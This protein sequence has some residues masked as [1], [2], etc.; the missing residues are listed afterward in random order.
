MKRWWKW[1]VAVLI[2]LVIAAVAGRALSTRKAQ[3]QALAAAGAAKSVAVVELATSDVTRAQTREIAQGLPVTGALKAVNSAF[4]KARVAGELQGLSVREGD[5]VKAGQVIARIESTEFQSRLRQAQ[6]Q[7]DAARSQVDI[8]Q[9]QFDNNKALVDQG[10]IS[11]TALDTSAASLN[12]ARSTHQAALAAAD[13]ARKT[14]TDTVLVAPISGI[15][16]QRL[17]Q[18]GE[19]VP[20]D[21]RIVEIVD[22]SR[23]ELEAA[24]SAGDATQVRVGQSAVLR[25]EGS[26][27]PVKARV[28][29]IN[30]ST[31]AGSRSVMVYL[32]VEPTAVLRQ[33][34]FAEGTLDTERV[35]ALA[36]PLSAVRTDKPQ[37]YVQVVEN[38][39]IAHRGVTTGARGQADGETMVAVTGVAENTVVVTGATGTLR[40]GTSVKFTPLKPAAAPASGPILATPAPAPAVSAPTAAR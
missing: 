29:R 39:R 38:E 23:V 17:A 31:Q 13:I 14:L 19:R 37:P 1:M 25:I 34:L 3:Q 26:A 16:S 22:L 12:T 30:P 36:V 27:E 32:A 21:A 11:K 7:A 40:E 35:R 8:A 4:V 24:V 5:T 6:D 20:V 2:L 10:F 28:A 9:R 33:G 15:I 18:P